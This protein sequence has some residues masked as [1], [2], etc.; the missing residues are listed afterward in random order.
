MVF[1]YLKV[2]WYI[3]VTPDPLKLGYIKVAPYRFTEGY[4][5]VQKE[6]KQKKLLWV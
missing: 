1:C 3:R 2:Y 6:L 4:I 5:N